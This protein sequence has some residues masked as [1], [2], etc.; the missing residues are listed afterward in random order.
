MIETVAFS[1][2]LVATTQRR[3]PE[4]LTLNFDRYEN[5]RVCISGYV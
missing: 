3:K 4:Q 1:E 5:F 2:R